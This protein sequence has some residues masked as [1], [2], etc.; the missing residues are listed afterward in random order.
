M[1]STTSRRLKRDGPNWPSAS[2]IPTMF[3]MIATNRVSHAASVESMIDFM[4]AGP[5][6]EKR[7][8][9]YE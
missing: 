2:G 7:S 3:N 6:H 8:L 5:S 9:D 1:L 4:F